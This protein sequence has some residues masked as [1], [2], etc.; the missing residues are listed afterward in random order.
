MTVSRAEAGNS[1]ILRSVPEQ[2]RESFEEV[3]LPHLDAAYTLARY[4]LRSEDEAQ[5]AVQESYL[6]A[7]RHF[8]GF[9]GDNAR[10]WLLTIV[11]HC[12]ATMRSRGRRDSAHVE[13]DEHQHSEHVETN[14]PELFLVRSESSSSIRRALDALSTNDREVL[15]LREVHGLSYEEIARSLGAP[16][17]TVMSRLSRARRRMQAL[18]PQESR[19][20]G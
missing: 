11:R 8:A 1:E 17:G 20:A 15:I 16:I 5:D 7:L 18:L 9:R 6:R 2:T 14:T 19:D 3:A 4:L 13:F 10:A 12:C